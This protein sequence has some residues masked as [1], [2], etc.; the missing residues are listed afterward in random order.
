MSTEAFP[1][2]V[3][4]KKLSPTKLPP[5]PE[6]MLEYIKKKNS[7]KRIL[8][9]DTEAF[10]EQYKHYVRD[11]EIVN[12]ENCQALD[13]T[14]ASLRIYEN[15]YDAAIAALKV[16]R[17]EFQELSK[18][19]IRLK[20]DFKNIKCQNEQL[21]NQV[22]ALHSAISVIQNLQP[23]PTP[24]N[25]SDYS[26]EWSGSDRLPTIGSSYPGNEVDNNEY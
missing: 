7:G 2:K 5:V 19:H 24:I 11:V 9:V 6:N 12:E 8:K 3:D 21:I 1:D 26:V 18:K 17:T 10:I 13:L 23:E 22:N 15:N 25:S 4:H 16:Q 14:N 20:E